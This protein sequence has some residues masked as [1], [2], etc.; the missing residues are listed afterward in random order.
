MTRGNESEKNGW[1]IVKS[2]YAIDKQSVPLHL[3]EVEPLMKS[4]DGELQP[5]S[6]P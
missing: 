6:L 5:C 1:K 4:C 3:F 2:C